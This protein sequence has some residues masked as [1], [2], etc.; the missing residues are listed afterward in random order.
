MRRRTCC[1]EVII[2]RP[3]AGNRV[4]CIYENRGD[5]R[6]PDEPQ[7][8]PTRLVVDLT[9]HTGGRIKTDRSARILS[10]VLESTSSTGTFWRLTYRSM[11]ESTVSTAELFVLM[12]SDMGREVGRE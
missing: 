4:G 1:Q 8:R 12:T 5:D 11:A 10:W 6:S 9:T 3:Y 2:H 7:L